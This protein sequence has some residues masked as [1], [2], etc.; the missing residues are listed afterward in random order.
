MRAKADHSV[1]QLSSQVWLSH[2]LT[3]RIYYLVRLL[4]KIGIGYLTIKVRPVF[5]R[6]YQGEGAN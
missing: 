3:L 5:S 1:Y 4:V 6:S 2:T